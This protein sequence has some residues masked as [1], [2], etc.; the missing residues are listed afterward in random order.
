MIELLEKKIQRLIDELI[1]INRKSENCDDRDYV[2]LSNQYIWKLRLLKSTEN[3]LKN[4][5]NS[6][7]KF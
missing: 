5:L 3:R 2:Y 6:S 1:E 4:Y 7:L